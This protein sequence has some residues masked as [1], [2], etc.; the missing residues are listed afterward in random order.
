MFKKILIANRGE[1]ACRIIRTARALGIRTVAVYSDADANALHVA[2]ADEAY[3]LGPAPV[4]KSYLNTNRII[5]VCKASGAEA[6]HPGYGFFSENP[7]FVE[8]VEAA[9]LVFVGPSAN[10]IRQM[11]L[12]DAAKRLMTEAGVPVVPG[13]QGDDQDAD[14]LRSRAEEI[15]FP[16]L[17]KARAGGGGRGMRRVNELAAFNAALKA[18]QREAKS[19]FGDD[20]VLIETCLTKARHIEIQIFGDSHGNAVHLFE[21]DCSLQR[22][23][24]KVIEEAPAPGMTAD[25]RA[26]MCAAAIRAGKA[27]GYEGAGTVEFIADVS[28]GLRPDRFY[29]MEMNTRLQVEHPVTE[30]ITGVDLVEWQ[31]RV[32][33]GEPLPVAQEDLSINGWAMEARIYAEDSAKGFLPATGRLMHLSLPSEKAGLRVESGIR[34]GDEITPYYDPMIAKLVVH[35]ATRQAARNKLSAALADCHVA[36]AVTNVAF[37]SALAAHAVFAT[38]DVDTGLIERD[39]KN[40][41]TLQSPPL[42]ALAIGALAALGLTRF[43]DVTDPWE[44]LTGWRHWS[45]AKQYAHL[46]WK[47]ERIDIDVVCKGGGAFLVGTSD[48]EKHLTVLDGSDDGLRINFAGHVVSAKAVS[49]NGTLT[50][51]F[52]G[53]AYD[54]GLPDWLAE[55]DEEEAGGDSVVSPMPGLVKLVSVNEGADVSR[56]DILIVLE[57]MKME[58]SLAAPRDGKVAALYV[59]EGQQV[60]DGMVLL[61]LG[62]EDD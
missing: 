55:S 30:F 33:A 32:A 50:V 1:I 62:G 58:H 19:S 51:F 20:H 10:A 21:R 47:S 53:Q 15:G 24:Q 11:G 25:M 9:G 4:L 14:F 6:V 60:E 48:G 46:Q 18:A 39:L 26:E 61:A 27:I 2:M 34:E 44:T 31:F 41:I 45:D 23:H 28:K 5:E 35:G 42:E 3:R 16:V 29:F 22:R 57:A 7:D 40:L 36:G 49:G 17:V 37:L 54:F 13:Y 8:A 38:G 52:D 43:R 12:K 59:Q 56:G